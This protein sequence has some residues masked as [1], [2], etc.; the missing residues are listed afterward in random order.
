M[1]SLLGAGCVA[2][3]VPL[4]Q[5][6]EGAPA[7]E[8]EW[9]GAAPRCASPEEIAAPEVGAGLGE[10]GD[11]AGEDVLVVGAGEAVVEVAVG[12]LS[13]GWFAAPRP[14]VALPKPRARQ[15][16]EDHPGPCG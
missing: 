9:D 16:G 4:Y 2:G 12:K 8:H 5:V 13:W 7:V 11:G 1:P 6:R 3:T 10:L 15:H 14:S